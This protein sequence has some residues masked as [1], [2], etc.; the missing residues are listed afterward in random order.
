MDAGEL[1]GLDVQEGREQGR[2]PPGRKFRMVWFDMP[3]RRRMKPKHGA[4]VVRQGEPTRFQVKL[5]G[6]SARVNAP[7]P[8]EAGNPCVLGFGLG[9]G[10][11][12]G[13]VPPAP[14]LEILARPPFR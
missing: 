1:V 9:V 6:G 8:D 2:M 3:C 10:C 7:I 5:G 11:A 14:L 4:G 13:F 12:L